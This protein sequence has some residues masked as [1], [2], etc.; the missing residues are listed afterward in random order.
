ML[1]QHALK[2]GGETTLK[3]IYNT[4]GSPGPFTKRIYMKTNL[5]GRNIV[6]AAIK[7][8][9]KAAAA[10]KIRVEPRKIYPE[11]VRAGENFSQPLQVT[12]LGQIPLTIKKIYNPR[13]GAVALVN[14]PTSMTVMPAQ[15]L[16]IEL[17][18]QIRGSGPFVEVFFFDTN[19]QNARE[20]Q[21][22]VM[23]IKQEAES[24]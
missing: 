11:N 16:T 1:G 20:G 24:R 10:A 12:N 13:N 2:P 6:T 22:A 5:T 18:F 3:V 9:V 8:V 4:A 15:T 7:G 21:Y 19:A 14:Q 17:K 23:L